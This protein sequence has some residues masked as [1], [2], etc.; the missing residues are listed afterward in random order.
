MPSNIVQSIKDF[1][2]SVWEIISDG[3]LLFGGPA[4]TFMAII[5]IL[6][7]TLVIYYLL[8]LM[9]ETRAW[10]LLKGIL[11]IFAF[12]V[13]AGVIGL[14]TIGFLLNRTI[15]LFA[16]AFVVIFQPELRR[17]LETLAAVVSM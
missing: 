12:A 17:A 16:I 5:D 3:L 10:Q 14:D 11:L 2:S 9:R 1:F 6:A 8:K 4:D 7:T 13:F 15:S